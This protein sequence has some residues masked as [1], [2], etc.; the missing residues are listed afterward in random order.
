M[1][2]A[3]VAVMSLVVLVTGCDDGTDD[4]DGGVLPTGSLW[5]RFAIENEQGE[6]TTA[7]VT[8]RR[9]GPE[10]DSVELEE[11]GRVTC[12]GK[13]LE[14]TQEVWSRVT[15]YKAV[16]PVLGE[17]GQYD[18]LLTR[19]SGDVFEESLTLPSSVLIEE[20]PSEVQPGREVA[21]TLSAGDADELQVAVVAPC[22]A[23]AE[24]SLDGD[25]QSATL[26]GDQIVCA[27]E[28]GGNTPPCDGVVRAQRISRGA[29]SE[30]FAGGET[31]GVQRHEVDVHAI[32]E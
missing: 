11:G 4:V 23:L 9:G 3:I 16:V 17:G 15:Y 1:L 8:F 5:V 22:L 19:S 27:C 12:N 28:A 13:R 21:V 25:A 30:D 18:F 10:A 24:V 26:T 7:Y 20:A 32:P 6:G 2:R 31:L 29:V 14:V